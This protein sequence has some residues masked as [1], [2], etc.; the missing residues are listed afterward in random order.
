M[1]SGSQPWLLCSLLDRS[2]IS[3]LKQ[4]KWQKFFCDSDGQ[5][6]EKFFFLK[7][8]EISPTCYVTA[9]RSRVKHLK[10]NFYY[11]WGPPGVHPWHWVVKRWW[12]NVR[13]ELADSHLEI[14]DIIGICLTGSG[15]DFVPEILRTVT[16]VSGQSVMFEPSN[17]W[18]SWLMSS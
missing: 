15:L 18:W 12:D 6:G 11:P 14:F 1:L 17:D 16:P 3:D 5:W 4:T 13:A 7:K 9:A 8:S 10:I 2:Q